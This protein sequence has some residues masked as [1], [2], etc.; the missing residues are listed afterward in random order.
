L[1]TLR[2]VRGVSGRAAELLRCQQVGPTTATERLRRQRARSSTRVPSIKPLRERARAAL[3]GRDGRGPMRLQL[4]VEGSELLLYG[5]AARA[6][7]RRERIQVLPTAAGACPGG[8][9]GVRRATS[10]RRRHR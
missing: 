6:E 2:T 4:V 10:R 3:V 9:H 5:D 8:R 1:F 7:R